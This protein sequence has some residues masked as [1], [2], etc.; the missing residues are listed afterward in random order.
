MT[1]WAR[2]SLFREEF[3]MD[4]WSLSVEEKE[5]SVL[6][7]VELE[8]NVEWDL[9]GFSFDNRVDMITAVG[10]D[11]AELVMSEDFTGFRIEVPHSALPEDYLD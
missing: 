8:G 5:S 11:S 3:D 7:E 2:R 10:Q 9:E 4:N 6:F 1:I